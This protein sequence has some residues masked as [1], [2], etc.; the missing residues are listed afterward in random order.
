MKLYMAVTADEYE[1]PMVV[2]ESAIKLSEKLGKNRRYVQT[3]LNFIRRKGYG[4]CS[5]KT[6][7]YILKEV[8]VSDDDTPD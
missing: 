3:E 5:G 1:L 7:G 6:R 4:K 2:E 8:E